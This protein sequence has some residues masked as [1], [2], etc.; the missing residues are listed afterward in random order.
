MTDSVLKY[1][2]LSHLSL[3]FLQGSQLIALRAR[4]VGGRPSPFASEEPGGGDVLWRTVPAVV[5]LAGLGRG[6][7]G[8]VGVLLSSAMLQITVL[9]KIRQS[10]NTEKKKTVRV[11]PTRHC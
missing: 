6:T 8:E 11:C 5:C 10:E 2:D 7:V 1:A 3:L 9:S 4:L